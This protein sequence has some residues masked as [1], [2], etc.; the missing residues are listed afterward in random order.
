M[1]LDF[2][3]SSDPCFFC[4]LIEADDTRDFIEE[5]ELTIA[6][7]NGVQFQEGQ[8]VI[9]PRRHATTLF[10]LTE[11]EAQ[12]I[13]EAARRVG[14]AVSLAFEAEGLLLYQNNGLAS[15]QTVPHFH[16]HVIPQRADRGTWGNGSPQ[17]AQAEGRAPTPA[18]P[19]RLTAGEAEAMAGRI[20]SFL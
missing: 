13:V 10:E 1:T 8:L 6:R 17:L 19:K 12:A 2:P 11:D 9:L 20:R 3:Q 15:G 5:T 18:D 14:A 7:V 16:L 4:G